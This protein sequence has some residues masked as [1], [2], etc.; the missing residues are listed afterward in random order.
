MTAHIV[1]E[2]GKV[3]M[4]QCQIRNSKTCGLK[5][6]VAQT[7]LIGIGNTSAT[8][9]EMSARYNCPSIAFHSGV[10]LEQYGSFVWF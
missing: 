7:E 6:I 5:Y 3:N 1:I 4:Q 9:E 10:K 2:S 8:L